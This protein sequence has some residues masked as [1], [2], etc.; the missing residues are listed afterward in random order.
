[1]KLYQNKG[2]PL[3]KPRE[4]NRGH[5]KEA[6]HSSILLKKLQIQG[7]RE[8]ERERERAKGQTGVLSRSEEEEG[9]ACVRERCQ[10]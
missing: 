10:T 3:Q 9:S 1:M 6:N 5:I 2:A 8:R 7:E 4:H